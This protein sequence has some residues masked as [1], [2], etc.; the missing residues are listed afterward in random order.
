[1]PANTIGID[2]FFWDVPWGRVPSHRLSVMTAEAPHCKPGLL[3]G[4]SKLAALAAKR[5]KEREEAEAAASKCNSESE[6][7][8]AMLDKLTVRSKVGVATSFHDCS[9]QAARPSRIS[10]YPIRRR[11]SSPQPV[12]PEE[13][14]SMEVDAPQQAITTDTP[15]QRAS[16]SIFA[17][18]LFGPC[19]EKTAP[20]A[21]LQAFRAPYSRY[22]EL[23][24]VSFLNQAGTTP[25]EKKKRKK[26]PHTGE[27]SES[28]EK[29]VLDESKVKSQNLDVVAEFEK[30]DLKRIAN[31]V[32]IGMLDMLSS[33]TKPPAPLLAAM[34][35]GTGTV[36][37]SKSS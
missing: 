3:G 32:V 25:K 6:A 22:R 11:S 20:E 31:F 12:I 13:E 2:D 8:L 10:K 21:Q 7:A 34:T 16:A 14:T 15:A 23:C 9:T 26:K 35:D 24:E 17:T 19:Q 36:W 18:T 1:M 4:S 27:I 33:S 30:S 5:R 29:L 28:V 37:P